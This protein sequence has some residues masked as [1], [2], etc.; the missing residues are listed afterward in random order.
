MVLVYR[1]PAIVTHFVERV[2]LREAP[3]VVHHKRSRVVLD[4][5]SEAS[6]AGDCDSGI[7]V[8]RGRGMM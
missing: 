3:R 6:E 7:G 4:R 5:A 8:T 1:W 2:C